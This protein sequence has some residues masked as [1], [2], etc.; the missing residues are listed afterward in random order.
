MRRNE[1]KC[2]D[3]QL[4]NLLKQT[5]ALQG[6]QVHFINTGSFY[7]FVVETANNKKFFLKIYPKEQTLVPIHPN[8]ESIN[9]AAIA[10]Y[11][12]RCEFEFKYIPYIIQTTAGTFCLNTPELILLLS[13]YIEG[14]HPSYY[15]N[16]L[17]AEK[18]AS[19]LAKLHQIPISEFPKFKQEDFDISY[20]LGLENWLKPQ[21]SA[22]DEIYASTLLSRL[23]N[24]EDILKEKLAQLKIWQTQFQQRDIPL[25]LTHGDPHHYNVLQTEHEV[26]LVDWDGIKIAPIE[27][28]L[29]HYQESS[30]LNFYAKLNIQSIDLELCKFYQ[31]QRFFED[32]RYYL[33]QIILKKNATKQ[34]DEL[35]KETFLNHWG[36][37][38]CLKK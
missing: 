17:L 20:A 16:Q 9:Y 26:W 6:T 30:L 1:L 34:Q 3:P 5:Y 32:T 11:R 13:N 22:K 36:W 27:R 35:D 23:N 2:S 19:I 21:I 18:L 24:Y 12:F 38:Y 14:S 33:E 37:Q 10:L 15:P 25:A 28:D 31:L 8:L 7:S 4:I 29:W